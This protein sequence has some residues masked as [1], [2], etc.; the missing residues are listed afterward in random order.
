MNFYNAIWKLCKERGEYILSV[1]KA[2]GI[3]NST[4]VNWSKGSLTIENA[5]RVADYF[6]LT[7]DELYELAEAADEQ[8]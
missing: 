8:A 7:L 3:P 4:I 6:G 1:S 2:T 5:K